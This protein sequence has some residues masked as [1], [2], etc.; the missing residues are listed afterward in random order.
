MCV[1]L[2][3]F[4]QEAKSVPSTRHP[5]TLQSHGH[6]SVRN[7]TN[8][9]YP[10]CMCTAPIISSLLLIRKHMWNPHLLILPAS[11]QPIEKPSDVSKPIT[12]RKKRCG[13]Y[14]GC[15]SPDC[16][17]CRFCVYKKKDRGTGKL[18]KGCIYQQCIGRR[19]TST[20]MMT[21]SQSNRTVALIT[22]GK[23]L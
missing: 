9:H 7:G 14:V 16:G 23:Q 19:P 17:K 11:T 2:L 6:D 18:K 5:T 21:S 22:Q 12:S 8:K 13:Q 20:S 1:C 3:P 4:N 15:T 10:N